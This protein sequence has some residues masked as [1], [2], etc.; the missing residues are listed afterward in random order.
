[1]FVCFTPLRDWLFSQFLFCMALLLHFIVLS[2][3]SVQPAGGPLWGE[4]GSLD[5]YVERERRMKKTS[6]VHGPQP[7]PPEAS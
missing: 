1:M 2:I 3:L 4:Q 7:W 6:A 5:L